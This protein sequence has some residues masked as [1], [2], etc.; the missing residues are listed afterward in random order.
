MKKVIVVGT[1]FSGSIISR[2]IA[3]EMNLDVKVIEKRCH[4]GGNAYDEY[5]EQGILIQ[6]YGP[7]YLN[8]DHYEVIKFLN[9]YGELYPHDAKLLSYI[10]DEYVQLPFNFK[11]MQQL[12]GF[13][14]SERYLK[15]MRT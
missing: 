1:G 2:K 7:H 9:Q 5:D 12:V 4:I 11:T 15:K 8:T 6:R 14:N 3:E 13:E 10:D